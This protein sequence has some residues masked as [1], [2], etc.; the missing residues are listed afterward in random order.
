MYFLVLLFGNNISNIE[1]TINAKH[2]FLTH[3]LKKFT[4]SITYLNIIPVL[5]IF[6]NNVVPII[7]I[8]IIDTKIASSILKISA[9]S[10]NS[11][12]ILSSA[13]TSL[14]L[15]TSL[16]ENVKTVN[17]KIGKMHMPIIIITPT[18]PTAFF[19]ITPHPNTL[20]TTSPKIF[21]T[22]GTAELTIAFA[23]FAVIPSTELESVPSK[24]TTPTNIVN[25]VPKSHTVED[26]KN[27]KSRDVNLFLGDYCSRY[28]KHTEKSNLIFENNIRALAR[29]K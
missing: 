8:N 16:Y 3:E 2:K 13:I 12:T 5:D 18:K 14:T 7:T 9:I 15:A 4:T 25:I 19:K 17:F 29:K 10:S 21:P 20:S 24:E 1:T 23:V 26:F 28:Y 27:I 11:F 6:I 22:T